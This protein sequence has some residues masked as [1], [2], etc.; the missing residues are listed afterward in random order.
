M[1]NEILRRA[2]GY[3]AQ[4]NVLPKPTYTFIGQPCGDLPVAACCRVMGV[5]ASGFS[6]W[7][8]DPSRTG[9]GLT[10]GSPNKIV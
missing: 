7:R 3:F 5:S 4:E 9:T 8:A 10:P 2:A 6:A 1:E